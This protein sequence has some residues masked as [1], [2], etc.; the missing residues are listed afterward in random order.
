MRCLILASLTLIAVPASAQETDSKKIS[1]PNKVICRSEPVIGS[2]LQT[3]RTCLTRQQ[4]L[5][6]ER[7]MRRTT[8]K[9]QDLKVTN[10]R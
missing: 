8:E 6:R 5:E 3:T 9:I 2:R 4:W 10:G 7:E 1:D